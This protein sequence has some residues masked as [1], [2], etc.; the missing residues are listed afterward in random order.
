MVRDRTPGGLREHSPDRHRRRG[1]DQSRR[2]PGHLDPRGN[3]Q[4]RPPA[5]GRTRATDVRP[6]SGSP[7]GQPRY[8]WLR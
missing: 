5:D 1:T 4:R 6:A 7:C 8:T 3:R 2:G